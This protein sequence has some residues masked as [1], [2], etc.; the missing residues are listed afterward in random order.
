MGAAWEEAF[1]AD[2]PDG[3][4]AMSAYL[5]MPE[6]MPTGIEKLDQLLGGGMT[7]GITVVG[8]GV[9][10]DLLAGDMPY[11]LVKHVYAT[12]SLAGALL[13]VALW[14]RVGSMGAMMAG[15]ALIV[16]IRFL[17]AHYHWNLP[18]AHD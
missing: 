8:G 17:S 18:K 16:V 5:G 2:R 15:T 1:T 12:A 11:I 10:R 9:I 6:P 4:L 13:C 14:P 7:R 3:E